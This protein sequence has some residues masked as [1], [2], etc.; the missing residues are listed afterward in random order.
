M[1]P[2]NRY[3][4]FVQT[5]ETGSFS[6]AAEKLGYTQSAISQM[7]HSLEEELET[8]LFIRSRKGIELTPDGQQF[9]PFIR[10]IYHAHC[11]LIEKKKELEGLES[12]I[13]RIGTFSSVSCNWIPELIKGFKKEYPKVHFD[14]KQ[15]EYTNIS[16]WIHD[17]SVDFGFINPDAVKDLIVHP[18]ETDEM[19]AI[20]PPNHPLSH[21]QMITLDELSSE[22]YILLDEGDLC[23]PLEFFKTHHMQ[24]NIQYKV[25]DDY[26]IMSM[27]E[28]GLGVSILPKLVLHRCHQNI[29]MK[30]IEPQVVRTIALSYKNKNVLP[31]ASRYFI[32]YILSTF[33]KKRT[34]KPK[35][36]SFYSE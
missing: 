16:N 10:N 18:L 1:F 9:L 21:N 20:L 12:G 29:V 5:Y 26:T 13:I 3:D 36:T 24:P 35:M 25:Y 4:A 2:L 33:Q 19:L 17:G 6:K 30:K 23:E 8:K 31:K 11:E 27:V 7:I 34:S 14:I 15:G 32:D 22:P 28:Q